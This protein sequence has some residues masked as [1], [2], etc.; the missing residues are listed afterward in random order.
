MKY[1]VTTAATA[2]IATATSFGVL[3]QTSPSTTAMTP[4]M[5]AAAPTATA[6]NGP[7]NAV[8]KTEATPTDAPPKKSEGMSRRRVEE[9]QTAL[10]DAG[11][12][13]ELDGHYGKSTTEALRDYQKQNGLRATGRFD[14][15]TAEKLKLPHWD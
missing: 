12:K 10:N 13:L 3:A 1:L 5:P 2:L 15:D 8:G 9:L 14:H 4:T 6:A 11:A 7:E